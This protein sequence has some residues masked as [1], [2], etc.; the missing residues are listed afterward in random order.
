MCSDGSAQ[1]VQQLGQRD[2]L[3]SLEQNSLSSALGLYGVAYMVMHVVP[4][5]LHRSVWCGLSVGDLLGLLTPYVIGIAIALT[6]RQIRGVCA[7]NTDCIRP[8]FLLLAGFA[9]Y[10][11]GHGI[12]LAANAIARHLL[13]QFGS[14]L[15]R[16]T[17]FLDEHL[18]HLL[19]H[20]GVLVVSVGFLAPRLRP[21][22]VRLVPVVVGGLCFGF[23][24]FTDAVE[25][26]T[27]PMML[28]AAIVV[29]FVS[30]MR[31]RGADT[32]SHT[33]PVLLFY[34]VGYAFA[35]ISFAVWLAWQGGFPQFS[36]R[37]II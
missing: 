5:F 10:T 24:Y 20:A 13:G 35:L 29:P 11:S 12:N 28:P 27:V 21:T 32:T 37:G 18:G 25:G 3:L 31:F 16:L 36:E 8:T 30:W 23:A 7:P 34:A 22:A 33:N 17:Y 1:T 14:P 26:Q 9:L 2:Q 15:Y 6:W 19:W 4:V